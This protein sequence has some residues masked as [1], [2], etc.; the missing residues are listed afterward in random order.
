MGF[1]CRFCFVEFVGGAVFTP[2]DLWPLGIPFD[3]LYFFT[4]PKET[5]ILIPQFSYEIT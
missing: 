3:F 4:D 5:I 1:K 2:Y